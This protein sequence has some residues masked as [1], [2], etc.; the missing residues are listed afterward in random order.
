MIFEAVGGDE[1]AK[2]KNNRAQPW[3]TP[4]FIY[5]RERVCGIVARKTRVVGHLQPRNGESVVSCV[6][7][8]EDKE[9]GKRDQIWFEN[10]PL[11][12]GSFKNLWGRNQITN[13]NVDSG[14]EV[15]AV[16]V[17]CIGFSLKKIHGKGKQKKELL[18]VG[19]RLKKRYYCYIPGQL[20]M[21]LR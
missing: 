19:C 9:S 3:E 8:W 21:S 1:I 5:N 7:V 2:L 6:W 14:T 16:G 4:V 18:F 17:E 13:E 11:G 20:G 10:I 12:E 15:E